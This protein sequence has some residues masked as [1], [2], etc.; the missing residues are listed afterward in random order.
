MRFQFPPLLRFLA[1]GR[2]PVCEYE[3]PARASPVCS[4]CTSALDAS[5]LRAAGRCRRCFHVLASGGRCEFCHG[6]AVFFDE[7]RSLFSLSPEWRRVVHRWKYDQ[8]RALFHAFLPALA[9]LVGALDS[10]ADD[11]WSVVH[12]DS[13]REGYARRSFQ[14]CQ[15]LSREIGR[16]TGM[17]YG[18]ALR[19]TS[20]RQSSNTR[21]GRF[22]R[23]QGSLRQTRPVP[24]RVLLIEDV[25]TTGATA[26]E[27]AR[28]LKKNGANFVLVISLLFR[29][30]LLT[31]SQ[32]PLL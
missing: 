1:P 25:F 20:N 3:S 2:C 14:P 11:P 32:V 26:N 18:A 27:A 12:I 4:S 10:P 30:D 7:H 17:P 15:D 5:A 29:E 16:W 23:V 13:G 22:F 24:G 21:L 6:R 8:E 31:D 28:I 19:K 9:R